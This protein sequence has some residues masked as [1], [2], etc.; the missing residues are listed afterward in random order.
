M[1]LACIIKQFLNI[2]VEMKYK[3]VFDMNLSRG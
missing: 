1:L 3:F 2:L